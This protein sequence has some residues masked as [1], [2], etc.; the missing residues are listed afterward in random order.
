[1]KKAIAISTLI[2]AIAL[3]LNT[4]PVKAE[5]S[6]EENIGF[7]SGALAGAA[8]GGPVG[9]IVGAVTGVLVGEQVKQANQ[10]E[11]AQADLHQSKIAYQQLKQ[12]FNMVENAYQQH[13]DSTA[14]LA[15]ISNSFSMNLMFTTNS[16]ALSD[17]DREHIEKLAQVLLEHP[18]INLTLDGYSDPRGSSKH[19]FILSQNRV[20]AVKHAFEMLGIDAN[21]IAT[22]A[23][24]ELDGMHS[25][26]SDEFAL[27]RK[28]SVNL[29]TNAFGQVAQN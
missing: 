28:V 3:G 14:N 2:T 8:V 19:N 17:L 1:M 21:R 27:A 22:T 7:A 4:Q 13:Q 5:A 10:L 15:L 18:E 23:H 6:K 26:S 25:A 12:E 24:G 11:T 9:F 20:D 29:S 16:S